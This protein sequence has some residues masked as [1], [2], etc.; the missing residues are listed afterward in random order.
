MPGLPVWPRVL[1]R[2]SATQH[3]TSK[4]HPYQENVSGYASQFNNA[5]VIWPALRPRGGRPARRYRT[6]PTATETTWLSCRRR[7]GR[8]RSVRPARG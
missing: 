1:F 5:H 6:G 4:S 8:R 7:P 3:D 2:R